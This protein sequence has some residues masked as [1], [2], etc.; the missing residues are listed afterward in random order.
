MLEHTKY[1]E[2]CALAA[3]GQISAEEMAELQTHLQECCLCK[4]LHKEFLDINSIWLTQAPELEPE[5][6]GQ[7]L[8]L[9]TKILA[10]LQ[11]AGAN[12]SKP[13]R[14]KIAAPPNKL[15]FFPA[16]QTPAPLWAAAVALIAGFLGFQFGSHKHVSP[17]ESG[18]ASV[19]SVGATIPPSADAGL[20][21]K[22]QTELPKDLEQRL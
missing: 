10:T 7:R 14:D 5:M 2:F 20:A 1:E 6:Y 4:E 9:R 12:F 19:R 22:T 16:F 21:S 17:G 18:S 11:D 3:A 15:R 13:V 8:V